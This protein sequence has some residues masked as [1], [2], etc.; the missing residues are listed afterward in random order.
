MSCLGRFTYDVS[1][2]MEPSLLPSWYAS[3]YHI[4]ILLDIHWDSRLSGNDLTMGIGSE[5]EA[6]HAPMDC[7]WNNAVPFN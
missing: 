2:K 4:S 7:K 1:P 6:I 5:P 3:S